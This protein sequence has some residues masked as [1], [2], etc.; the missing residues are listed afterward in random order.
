MII[1]AVGCLAALGGLA[2]AQQP[3]ASSP[4]PPVPGYLTDAEVPDASL[5]LPP[6]PVKGTD[7][8][9]MD[10]AIFKATRSMEG[11]PRW[12]LAQN[13]NN[14]KTPALEKDFSCALGVRVTPQNAPILTRLLARA[15][16]DSKS[17]NDKAKAIFKRNRPYK[18]DAGNICV[19][20]TASLDGSYDYPSGHTMLSWTVGMI[21]SELAPDRTSQVMT[22]ARAYGES[23]VVCGVHN[24]SAI[25]GGR[26]AGAVTVAALNGS[27]AFRKDLEAARTELAGLRAGSANAVDAQVCKTE[28]DLI[29][30]TPY[31]Y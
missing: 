6:A 30:K 19:P 13:D 14:L 12:A 21:L 24:A 17:V 23:R 4:T 28:A 8:Y 29:A 2:V 3:P 18:I 25:E 7:R 15:D 5:V 22:R 9:A 20:H 31:P 27:M 11:S 10:R 26:T 1:A 16:R